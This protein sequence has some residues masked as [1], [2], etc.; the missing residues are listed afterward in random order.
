MSQVIQLRATP[1]GAS[2]G[3][4]DPHR[5]ADRAERASYPAE[6][7]ELACAGFDQIREIPTDAAGEVRAQ[8][9]WVKWLLYDVAI[10]GIAA[11]LWQRMS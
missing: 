3:Q 4:A 8:L 7:H 5:V 9:R 11:A 10:I 1:S 6:E 2:H